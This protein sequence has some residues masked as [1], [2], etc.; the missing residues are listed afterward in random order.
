MI[1]KGI[2]FSFSVP[3]QRK[4]WNYAVHVTKSKNHLGTCACMYLIGWMYYHCMMVKAWFNF[5]PG[6]PA[7]IYLTENGGGCSFGAKVRLKVSYPV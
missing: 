3:S 2:L 7:V 6:D 1:N 5:L 4:Q